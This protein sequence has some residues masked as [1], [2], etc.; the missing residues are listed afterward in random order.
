MG[1]QAIQALIFDYG[2]V[3]MRTVDRRPRQRLEHRFE[4]EPGEVYDVV[5]SSPR[6][7]DVQH[8]HIDGE[9][10][11][12]HVGEQVGLEP[13][14][15]AEFRHLFWSGDRL[16]EELV[17]LIRQLRGRGYRTALLSN[18]PPDMEAYVA[19]L[20]ITDAFDVVVISGDEGVT[21]PAPEIYHR[22]LDRLG[23]AAENAVFIDDMRINVEA[24]RRLGIRAARFRGLEPLRVWLRELGV[25]LP[26]Y[27][28]DPVEDVQAV[29]F[30]WGGVMEELPGEDDV[31]A[32]E[33]RLALAPGV[34]PGILWGEGWRRL[35]VGAISDQDY[36]R[37]VSEQLGFPDDQ[38]V[39]DFFQAFYTSDRLNLTVI[40][41]ARALRGQ[42]KIGLLS[43]AFPA[44]A[45][46][47]REQYG[48]DV[49]A[50]FDVYINSAQVGVSKPDPRI[51][52]L[53]LRQLDVHPRQTVFL[54]DTLRNVDIARELGIH[55]I[56][57]VDPA[58]SLPRLEALLGHPIGD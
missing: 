53:T 29:I 4:L 41:A 26:A 14:Q 37:R 27:R 44:Q 30:D 36:A 31:A 45:E 13:D 20:G 6:W 23:V 35:A 3:L 1:D 17:A 47:V 34:L 18:A 12:A 48:L 28:P 58:T 42:Y 2:G 5:F 11:W 40:E 22:T 54:D 57:F 38:S 39:L 9:A 21:K 25:S 55:A 24:A 33:R 56:Q 19:D 52:D 8:G 50:E 16:D 7:D 15:L 10:F 32:W 49:H 43:N 46:T 51:Y